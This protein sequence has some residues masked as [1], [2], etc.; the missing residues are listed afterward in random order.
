MSVHTSPSI[1]KDE[2]VFVHHESADLSRESRET[3]HSFKLEL[4]SHKS[5]NMC[6]VTV[7]VCECVLRLFIWVHDHVVPHFWTWV[8]AFYMTKGTHWQCNWLSCRQLW[9]RVPCCQGDNSEW[10]RLFFDGSQCFANFSWMT[11]EKVTI[12]T[13]DW[14]KITLDLS[15]W[16]D[17]VQVKER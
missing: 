14:G 15:S 10:S 17:I 11:V 3:K 5:F 4:H 9:V 13:G 2:R 8:Y 16:R 7:W 1:K 6:T 12:W